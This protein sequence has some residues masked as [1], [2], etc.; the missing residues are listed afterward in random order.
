MFIVS[1]LIAFWYI[2]MLLFV[3]CFYCIFLVFLEFSLVLVLFFCMVFLYYI[4]CISK[5]PFN[6]LSFRLETF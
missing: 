5:L 1:F 4:M 2:H 3:P 6:I